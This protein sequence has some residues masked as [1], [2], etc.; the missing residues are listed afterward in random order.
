[1]SQFKF[2]I[3]EVINGLANFEMKSKAA[4][5]LYA[6]AASDKLES[7]AKKDALWTDRTGQSR[8]TIKGGK[9]WEGDKCNVYVAGNTRYFPYLELCNDKEY[10]ILK[11]T[12]DK[13]SPE[14]LKGMN[15]LLGK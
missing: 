13:L 7:T 8:Q 15:N 11:P 9:Q 12:I 14:I 2:D 5:G 4:I 10:A 3:E 1:M 6:D